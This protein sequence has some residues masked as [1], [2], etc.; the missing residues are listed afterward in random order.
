MDSARF[1]AQNV[2]LQEDCQGMMSTRK[3]SLPQAAAIALDVIADIGS[4]DIRLNDFELRMHQRGCGSRAV[5]D[6][7]RAF[8]RR[9]WHT[10][11]GGMLCVSEAAFDAACN[12]TGLQARQPNRPKRR[13]LMP[14]LF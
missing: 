9:G 1:V 8:E 2:R 6:A 5:S 3:R 4:R 10:M 13:R 14:N 11:A 12:G 7:L